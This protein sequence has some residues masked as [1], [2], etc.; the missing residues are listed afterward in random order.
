LIGKQIWAAGRDGC[1]GARAAKVCRLG[2]DEF[3]II[4]SDCGDPRVIA[5]IVD[6]LLKRLRDP[7]DVNGNVL[8]LGCSAG[9][10]IA[11]HDASQAD[12]R[13]ANADLALYQAKAEGGH[14]YRFFL[15]ALRARAQ[16][17][18]A[19]GIELRRACA[20]GELELYF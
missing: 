7:F 2:G 6:L 20:E 13:I 1:C 16:A 12:A 10:A 19:L 17:R 8:H 11:P 9:I 14:G 5:E 3:V 4:V 18:R 15:P